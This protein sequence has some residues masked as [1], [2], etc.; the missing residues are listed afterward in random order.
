MTNSLKQLE[1]LGIAVMKSSG[2]D[3]SSWVI[4]DSIATN[5]NTCTR[6][7]NPKPVLSTLGSKPTSE[8]SV[9]GLSIALQTDGWTCIEW[10]D[11]DNSPPPVDIRA[12]GPKR[13][14]TNVGT[15]TL[16]K[17]YLRTLLAI[18]TITCHPQVEHFQTDYHYRWLLSNGTK[19]KSKQARSEAIEDDRSALAA[20]LDDPVRQNRGRRGRV[21][22]G[23]GPINFKST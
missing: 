6:L 12:G 14:Y 19:Y 18:G 3:V 13:F 16:S 17:Y 2:G 21:A 1:Q 22:N 5:L 11:G 15:H 8:M 10:E 20:L 9:L 23:A 4:K 7:F